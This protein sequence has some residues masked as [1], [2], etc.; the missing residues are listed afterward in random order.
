MW[1]GTVQHWGYGG[2]GMRPIPDTVTNIVQIAAG[3]SHCLALRG[4]GA[5]LAW[6]WNGWGQIDVPEGLT[7]VVAISAG[8]AISAA[9]R[10]DGTVVA[11]G[12]AE[13]AP[14]A[15]LSTVVQ[16]SAGSAHLLALRSNGTVV[17]W[18]SSSARKA[19]TV[20]PAVNNIVQVEAGLGFS[21]AVKADG[22][23]LAWGR[24]EEPETEYYGQAT[25]PPGLP[26]VTR[27]RAGNFHA[28]AETGDLTTLL[29][30]DSDRDGISDYREANLYRTMPNHPDSD[31]DAY[32]DGLEL[33]M[34]SSPLLADAFPRVAWFNP[35]ALEP[36]TAPFRLH[37]ILPGA[38]ERVLLQ[39]S[40]DLI[41]WEPLSVAPPSQRT[42]DFADQSA[43][44][45]PH[46]FYRVV[47]ASP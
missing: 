28:L 37:L 39:A 33:T 9:L 6:G 46:R 41:K 19:A 43:T 15:G 1:D 29:A 5:A 27:V 24:G 21:L 11:W 20:P 30:S 42:L 38:G 16:I 8:D 2:Y 22:S 14:P 12:L 3:A 34:R 7:N 36:S 18:G 44:N 17:A 26:P 31:G 4:D 32:S 47:P 10:A 13:A 25:P 40:T 23:L 45:F 35:S